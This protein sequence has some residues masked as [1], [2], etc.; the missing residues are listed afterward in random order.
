[1][2]Y[3]KEIIA[4]QNY[5]LINGL[6]AG[7]IALWHA[8]MSTNNKC[9]WIEWFT[10]PMS[11]LSAQ[12]GLSESGMRKARKTLIDLDLIE[13]RSNK[14]KAPYY[15]MKSLLSYSEI[16]E[17]GNRDSNRDSD[18]VGDRVGDRDSDRDS[19][20]VGS[21]LYKQNKR[22]QNKTILYNTRK[23]KFNNYEDENKTDYAA[24]E[25]AILDQMLE[26]YE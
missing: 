20:R 21:T 8:L 11:V 13:Y 17:V 9:G 10:I 19:D 26:G 14:A 12:C 18:R 6:S 22:K 2:N 5:A 25:E 3:L 15:K 23:S 1:M 24:L 4:F 7:Q 16:G